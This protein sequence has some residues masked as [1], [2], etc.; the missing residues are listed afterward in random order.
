MDYRFNLFILII[1]LS[2]IGVCWL[3]AEGIDRNKYYEDDNDF[4]NTNNK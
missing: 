1:S 2:F 3:Y 4:L